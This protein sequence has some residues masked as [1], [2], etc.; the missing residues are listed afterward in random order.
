[1]TDREKS[2]LK[3]LIFAVVIAGLFLC[4]KRYYEP[5][6]QEAK[7]ELESATQNIQDME[8]YLT[9]EELVTEER[10]WLAENEPAPTSPQNAQSALQAFCSQE[11]TDLDLEIKKE[12]PLPT[13]QTEGNFY[14]RARIEMLVSGEERTFYSWLKEVDDPTSFRRVTKLRL[15][16]LRDDDTLIEADLMIE[17]WFLPESENDL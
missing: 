11:A 15:S 4:Y 16:P 10:E 1:M 13:V 9:N 2:L 17:Q 14:H 7:L 3:V 5:A 12:T 8:Q 6:Y